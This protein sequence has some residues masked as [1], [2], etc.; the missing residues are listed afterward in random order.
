MCF[1]SFAANFGEKISTKSAYLLSIL[2]GALSA[3]NWAIWAFFGGCILSP[4]FTLRIAICTTNALCFRLRAAT[5]NSFFP[6][7]S[8]C[9]IV[10]STSPIV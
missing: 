6:I 3:F 2:I 9:L 4:E 5:A 7:S 8:T 10:G 1:K